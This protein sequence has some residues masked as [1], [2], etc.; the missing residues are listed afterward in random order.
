M[1]DRKS[2]EEEVMGKTES[3]KCL[4]KN[5]SILMH[6]GN[7]SKNVYEIIQ[8]RKILADDIRYLAK[9]CGLA[10][11]TSSCIKGCYYKNEYRSN[12]YYRTLISGETSMVPVKIPRKMASKRKI[13]K[14]ALNVGITVEPLDVDDYYGFEIDGNGRFVLG[15]FTVTHNTA[16]AKVID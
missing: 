5:T 4:G 9:S 8:K 3:D 6:D 1:L 7:C 10:A 16:T 13:N 11:Y 15:D 2:E 12:T 14:N